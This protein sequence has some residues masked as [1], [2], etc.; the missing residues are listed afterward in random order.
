M[1]SLHKDRLMYGDAAGCQG[2]LL[3]PVT[4]A[5]VAEAQTGQVDGS[6]SDAVDIRSIAM[7][8]LRAHPWLYLG[9]MRRVP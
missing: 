7:M 1:A 3:R 2:R 6:S 5:S 8:T 4:V 9:H